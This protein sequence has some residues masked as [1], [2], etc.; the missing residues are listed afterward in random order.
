MKS[1]LATIIVA[2]L[3]GSAF[4]AAVDTRPQAAPQETESV[5]PWP[6][7]L[8]TWTGPVTEG[9]PE[10]S[11]EGVDIEDID[12]QIGADHPGLSLFDNSMSFAADD[13][14]TGVEQRSLV[15]RQDRYDQLCGQQ[16][17]G[18]VVVW[19]IDN[20]IRHLRSV[21]RCGVQPRQCIR[22]TCNDRS[23]IVFCNDNTYAIDMA[24]SH[25]ANMANDSIARC[26]H[27]P[28]MPIIPGTQRFNANQG[29]NVILGECSF[30]S[31]GGQPV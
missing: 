31:A 29:Y 2:S 23:A 13:S 7:G 20:G 11:Y 5:A 22:T 12:R 27:N 26:Y 25:I 18:S 8:L 28:F 30:F 14:V 10:V 24:C 15:R 17:F 6:M 1:A 19:E 16:R 9:G 21:G 3:A 4:A